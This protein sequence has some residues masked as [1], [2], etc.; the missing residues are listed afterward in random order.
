[1][2]VETITTETLCSETLTPGLLTPP[3][4]IELRSAWHNEVETIRSPRVCECMIQLAGS[5]GQR[6][7]TPQ[8]RSPGLYHTRNEHQF[9]D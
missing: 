9:A 6:Y 1:L 8:K 5:H 3:L 7:Q 2:S 4:A